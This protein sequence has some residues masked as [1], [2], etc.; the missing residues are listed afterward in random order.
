[1]C[2]AH[3]QIVALF[4]SLRKVQSLLN[5]RA[6]TQPR[7]YKYISP[8]QLHI[9]LSNLKPHPP[10]RQKES[11]LQPFEPKHIPKATATQPKVDLHIQ[12]VFQVQVL[13][14]RSVQRAT[15]GVKWPLLFY[16]QEYLLVLVVAKWN[17][18]NMHV[19]KNFLDVCTYVSVSSLCLKC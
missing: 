19:I 12:I 18:P 5:P 9:F 11:N 4:Q 15:G 16:I 6:R 7:I 17:N 13:L 10:T 8:Y 1:M 2:S 3:P 14:D